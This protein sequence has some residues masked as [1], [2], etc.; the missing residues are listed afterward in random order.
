MSKGDNIRE[1]SDFLKNYFGFSRLILKFFLVTQ[2]TLGSKVA[3]EARTYFGYGNFR[4]F[5]NT[6]KPYS[7]FF[8]AFKE[9][10]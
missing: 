1:Y 7:A 6:K 8:W 4:K 3:S 10:I 5:K 9:K 2:T